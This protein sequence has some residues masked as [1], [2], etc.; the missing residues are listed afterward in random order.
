MRKMLVVETFIE[1]KKKLI[2]FFSIKCL[3]EVICQATFVNLR[4]SR[5]L[6]NERVVNSGVENTH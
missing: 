3:S 6:T 2:I 4:I 1:T 5:E